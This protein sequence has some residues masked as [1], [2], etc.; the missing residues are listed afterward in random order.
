MTLNA[1]LEKARTWLT[2]LGIRVEDS[3]PTAVPCLKVNRDDIDSLCG[4][5][6]VYEVF[7]NELRSALGTNKFTWIAKDKEWLY[8]D[9]F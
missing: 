4:I 9:T 6:V 2:E 3:D 1:S 5:G 7:L 8:L